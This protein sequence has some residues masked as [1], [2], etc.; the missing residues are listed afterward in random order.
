MLFALSIV[1]LFGFTALVIDLGNARQTARGVQS[2]S[3]A[4]VLAGAQDLPIAGVDPAKAATAPGIA[5]S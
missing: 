3:D 2:T 1:V 5:A 4:A